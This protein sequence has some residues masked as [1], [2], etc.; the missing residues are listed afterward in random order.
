M[1]RLY[2]AKLEATALK[3]IASS[4]DSI[5]GWIFP[6]VAKDSFG[7]KSSQEV[8]RRIQILT[9][10]NGIIPYWEDLMEDLAISEE[11][12]EILSDI[13]SGI[14]ESR[15]E[16]RLIVKRLDSYRKARTFFSL[17]KVI[18]T[19]LKADSVDLEAMEEDVAD[20]LTRLRRR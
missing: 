10:K 12:R 3:S 17:Q 15:R 2:S 16:A 19:K 4:A 9:S 18:S 20:Y 7:L 13:S 11:T 6:R 5:A 14:I 1:Q 8:F